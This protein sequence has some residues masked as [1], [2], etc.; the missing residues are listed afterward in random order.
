MVIARALY[1]AAIQPSFVLAVAGSSTTKSEPVAA[2]KA[3][4]NDDD[5][6]G[7]KWSGLIE[8]HDLADADRDSKVTVTELAAH[9]MKIRL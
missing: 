7:G 6:F 9:M 5:K 3:A 2:D 1:F 8:H 4:S